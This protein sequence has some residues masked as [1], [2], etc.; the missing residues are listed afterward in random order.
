M[1]GYVGVVG[2]RYE[3]DG[4]DAQERERCEQVGEQEKEEGETRLVRFGLAR[5]RMLPGTKRT[6]PMPRNASAAGKGVSK[7]KR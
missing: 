1:E 5:V 4:A 2:A 3:E 7:E 6:E